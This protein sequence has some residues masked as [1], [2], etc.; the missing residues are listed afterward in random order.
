MQVT[1][2]LPLRLLNGPRWSS[3]PHKWANPCGV[4]RTVPGT[5]R[6]SEKVSVPLVFVFA[7]SLRLCWSAMILDPR[8]AL[9]PSIILILQISSLFQAS[10]LQGPHYLLTFW[11][12]SAELPIAELLLDLYIQDLSITWH[13][14]S[15]AF[16][17]AL[18]LNHFHL[19]IADYP[20]Q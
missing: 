18:L 7:W 6:G 13:L 1:P 14:C 11:K 20:H 16:F 3:L 9:T 8:G 5:R 10:R 2:S 15:R 19:G 4:C 12:A 17:H